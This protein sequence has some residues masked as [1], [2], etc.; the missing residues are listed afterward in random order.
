VKDK[1]PAAGKTEMESMGYSL[2]Y[3]LEHRDL[4]PFVSEY[5]RK[6]NFVAFAFILLNILFLF[7]FLGTSVYYVYIDSVTIGGVILWFF[8]GLASTVP[9]IPLHEWLH[10]LAYKIC[11]ANE[12]S[13]DAHWKKFYITATADGFVMNRK[14]FFFVALMPFVTITFAG[15]WLY[16]ISPP[17]I[18]IM[19]CSAIVVH[20]T[21]CIGDFALMSYFAEQ[22]GKDVLTYDE[23]SSG[24]S[25]FFTK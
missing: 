14:Q 23:K 11:G 4:I 1:Y 15:F 21:M 22:K 16:F 25:Y 19:I 5:I 18:Q 12:I 17:Q 20:S 7:A 24:H 2:N 3:T 10:A 13:I 6:K 9:L 8:I